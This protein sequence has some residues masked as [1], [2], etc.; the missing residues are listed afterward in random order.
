MDKNTIHANRREDWETPPSIIG[1]LKSYYR[2]TVDLAASR[3]NKIADNYF[4]PDHDVAWCRDFLLAEATWLAGRTCWINPPYGHYLLKF[5]IK[6][7]QLAQAGISIVALLPANIETRW[8]WEN[9]HDHADLIC[10]RKG[11]IQ[12]LLNGQR[13]MRIDKKTGKLVPN[14]NPTASILATFN[15]PH[16]GVPPGWIAL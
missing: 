6:I 3:Q 15:L 2:F 9:I 13:A 5:T 1:P 12:F 8:F 11:R 16:L 10:G 14:S 4:G 7:R